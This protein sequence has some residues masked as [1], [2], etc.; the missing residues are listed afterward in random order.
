MSSWKVRD[1]LPVLPCH[2]G[3]P[4]LW[5]SEIPGELQYAKSLCGQCPI[6]SH[7]LTA[8]LE[9]TEPWG[10][11]GGEIFDRGTVVGAKR[12]RGRP[13]KDVQAA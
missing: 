1:A 12:A 6:R 8:A 2:I 7:C 10:V 5:F 13:R 4:D 9:R 11:W 3:D